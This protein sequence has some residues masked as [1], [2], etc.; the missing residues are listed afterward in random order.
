MK[1]DGYTNEV[2]IMSPPE[3][4]R[5]ILYYSRCFFVPYVSANVQLKN[6]FM[7]SLSERI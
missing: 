1:D 3:Y 5:I 7:L 4:I 6:I 2:G